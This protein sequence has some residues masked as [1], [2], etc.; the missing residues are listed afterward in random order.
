MT[1]RSKRQNRIRHVGDVKAVDDTF[2]VQ[3]NENEDARHMK[4]VFSSL[5][6]L[7]RK[8]IF[9]DCRVTL[10]PTALVSK[11]QYVRRR[12]KIQGQGACRNGAMVFFVLI[13]VRA[14]CA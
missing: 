1:T 3:L 8:T 4:C 7:C 12:G 2:S 14:S 13:C 11:R 9:F 5:K 10:R 6:D